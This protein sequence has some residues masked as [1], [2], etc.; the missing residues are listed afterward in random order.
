MP[1]EIVIEIK[2]L[3]KS[4]AVGKR[5]PGRLPQALAWGNRGREKFWALRD[6]DLEVRR[7]ESV[8]LVGRNGSGK[9]TLLQVIA[10][11]V[12]PTSGAFRVCG[13]VA[14][15]LELG[16]A[17]QPDFTGRE[18]VYLAASIFGLSRRQT[19]ERFDAIADF[20]GIGSFM[21]QPVKYYSSGMYARLAFAV[22]VH[23]DP[24][25]L[26]IDEML[27]VGD[28]EFR[29]K[30]D[31]FLQ[32]YRKHGTLLFVSHDIGAVARLC[33][34][35]VW[36]DQGEVRAVG[37][38]QE[39][40]ER[41]LRMPPRAART[42]SGHRIQGRRGNWQ[43]PPP[44]RL[45]ADV[46]GKERAALVNRVEILPFDPDAPWHGHGGAII[47]DAGFY[48]LDG[49]LL[50]TLAG[51]DEVELRIAC[52][53]ERILTQPIV[54]FLLRD[55]LGQT[56]LGDNTFLAYCDAAP[57]VVPGQAFTAA[58]RFQ[59]PYLALG[60]FTLAPSIIE[61]TQEDHIHLHWIEE[62]LILRVVASHV[63]RAI[64]GVPMTEIRVAVANG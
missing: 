60:T 47:E 27:S 17:F 25:I 37:P 1:P 2:G 12:A 56:V 15:A 8:G 28:Q 39:I 29:R 35:A 33:D 34:R 16:A 10:G 48:G 7:G 63:R 31:R 21:E 59:F 5:L 13:R 30:C 43:Q 45:V 50:S 22:F 49:E 44:P 58:F 64:V 19:A 20:A 46:R 38:A 11:A 57:S 55:R 61:G 24:E 40:C 52:R 14:A 51:G 18:N 6:I 54:G 62:A 4:Y 26:V 23:V 3:S 32:N 41:Y 53:A 9:S 36:L 42:G